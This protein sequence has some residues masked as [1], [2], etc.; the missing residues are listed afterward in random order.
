[1]T[2]RLLIK[3]APEQGQV[4]MFFVI[5]V[6]VIVACFFLVVDVGRFLVM[7]S[8][9]RSMADMSALAGAGALNLRAAGESGSFVLQPEWAM[10]RASNVF[11]ASVGAVTHDWASYTMGGMAVDGKMIWVTVNASCESIFGGLFGVGG[12]STSVTA[13][14][15]AASG[16]T[17]ER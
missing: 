5:L 1:M 3:G 2:R 15:R 12:Y 17:G 14:G 16:I 10:T 4:G 6:P 9:A 7:R 8:Q 11:A 13:V